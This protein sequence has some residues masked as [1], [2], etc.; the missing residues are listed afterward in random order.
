MGKDFDED[1]MCCIF[2]V[3]FVCHFFYRAE[4][5]QKLVRLTLTYLGQCLRP[6]YWLHCLEKLPL[7]PIQHL[8]S[9]V[10]RK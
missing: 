5:S 4:R 10:Y 9:N 6:M 1:C 7:F 2:H 3:F 8:V